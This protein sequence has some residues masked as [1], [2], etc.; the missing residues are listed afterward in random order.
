GEIGIGKM[1][2]TF[3]DFEVFRL[4]KLEATPALVLGMDVLG[5]VDQLMIDYRRAEFRVL[6][7][8]SGRPAL[9]RQTGGGSRIQ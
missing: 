6:L 1:R 2:V 5:T 3:G 9:T 8:S 4:W 7:K